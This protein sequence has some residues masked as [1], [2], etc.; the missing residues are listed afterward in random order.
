M[1]IFD[2]NLKCW[3]CYSC[4]FA[5]EVILGLYGMGKIAASMYA[6]LTQLKL[7]MFIC[8]HSLLQANYNGTLC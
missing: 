7:Y 2:C 4:L 5:C 6:M 1:Q 8:N 3:I